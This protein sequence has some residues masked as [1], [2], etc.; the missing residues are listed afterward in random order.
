[1][2]LPV[3]GSRHARRSRRTGTA[4]RRRSPKP[5][6]GSC[7]RCR[8]TRGASRRPFRNTYAPSTL[9][10]ACE[11]RPDSHSDSATVDPKVDSRS[12]ESFR[13]GA[14]GVSS[15][16]SPRR[17]AGSRR[18][19]RRHSPR[20]VDSTQYGPDP[21]LSRSAPGHPGFA[22]LFRAAPD[23]V[24]PNTIL[25]TTDASICAAAPR[26]LI[27]GSSRKTGGASG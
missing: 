17:R 22:R 9:S 1:M 8:G 23:A 27:A 11:M 16:R 14:T 12:N 6:D 2:A 7:A 15:S 5:L 13:R 25:T 10:G 18:L 24:D 20:R 19:R 21:G 3:L 26:G 4:V